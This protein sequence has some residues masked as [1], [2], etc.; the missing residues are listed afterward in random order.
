MEH[1]SGVFHFS[2]IPFFNYSGKYHIHSVAEKD[3][4]RTL[5]LTMKS[6]NLEVDFD[7]LNP[8]NQFYVSLSHDGKKSMI[9]NNEAEGIILKS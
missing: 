5:Y 8:F 6:Q 9:F 4:N 2:I 7:N 3:K 1:K